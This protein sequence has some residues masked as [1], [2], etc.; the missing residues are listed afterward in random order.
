MR[1]FRATRA[2]GLA[3]LLDR[4]QCPADGA[5]AASDR[6]EPSLSIRT[7]ATDPMR[8]FQSGRWPLGRLFENRA[9]IVELVEQVP[10]VVTRAVD[11]MGM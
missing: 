8:S 2:A 9:Q 11:S 1:A 10:D 6:T 3:T 4:E 5:V 7:R